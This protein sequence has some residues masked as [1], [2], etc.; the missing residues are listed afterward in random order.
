MVN[1]EKRLNEQY[2]DV[3]FIEEITFE[4]LK[5]IS[6]EKGWCKCK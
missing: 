4:Q 1:M 3:K 2:K 6:I 5:K